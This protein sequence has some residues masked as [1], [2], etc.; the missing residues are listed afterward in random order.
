MKTPRLK[1][2]HNRREVFLAGKEVRLA[3]SEYIILHALHA[4]G[5]ALTREQLSRE[6]GHSSEQIEMGGRVVDQHIARLRRKL[7]AD[8]NAIQTVTRHGYKLSAAYA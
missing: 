7:K 2:D 5:H 4:T 1:F 3:P 6:I 8:R